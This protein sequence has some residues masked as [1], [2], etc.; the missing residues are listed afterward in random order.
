MRS[1]KNTRELVKDYGLTVETFLFMVITIMDAL[2]D[3]KI[4]FYV[5]FTAL[6]LMVVILIYVIYGHI[7]ERRLENELKKHVQFQLYEFQDVYLLQ[8]FEKQDCQNDVGTF[9]IWEGSKEDLVSLLEEA[10]AWC[11]KRFEGENQCQL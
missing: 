3:E 4:F 11:K 9:F 8:L 2:P 10:V 6:I 7:I 5:E 1:H